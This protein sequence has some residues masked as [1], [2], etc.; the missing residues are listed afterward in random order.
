MES[1]MNGVPDLP[2]NGILHVQVGADCTL[3]GGTWNLTT[4]QHGAPIAQ[5][6]PPT[7]P[8]FQQVVAYLEAKPVPPSG[9]MRRADEARAAVAVCLRWGSYFAVLADPA[10]PDAP[11]I[12]DGQA[13]QIDDE[14]MA[15]MAI[16]ISA[17]VAWWLTLAGSDERRYEDLVARALAYLPT[18]RKTVSALLS[19]DVLLTSTVPELG[20]ELHGQWPAD[21]LE[22]DM[23]TAANHGIRV[24]A[25]TI[26]H[27]AWRNGPIENV[28]AGRYVGYG[29]NERRVLPKAEKSIIRHAQ[30]GLFSGL[31]A[32]DYLRY[33]NAWPPPAERVLPFM[34]GLIGPRD[35]SCTELSRVVE[36]PLRGGDL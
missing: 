30:D 10:R 6:S 3:D 35:W 17:G 14:E 5:I 33:D 29:L 27:I 9:S 15:R 13:S 16:E 19:G 36:L 11:N 32:A 20:A 18:G 1:G 31:K 25:N 34:H 22:Q 4:D 28:H 26:T 23:Q 21:R 7:V 24:I 12:D 2:A 8:M